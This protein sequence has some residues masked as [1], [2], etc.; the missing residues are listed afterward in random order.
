MTPPELLALAE[1]AT[2]GPWHQ[3]DL[4]WN[5]TGTSVHAGAHDP[6]RGRTICDTDTSFTLD[7]DDSQDIA[8]AAYIAAADP[9]TVIALL[10]VMEAVG[11]REHHDHST[12]IEQRAC[13]PSVRDALA[14]AEKEMGK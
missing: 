10:R 11:C 12:A 13:A 6:H 4:P 8:N 2:K 7:E 14:A 3:T 5:N 9:Q 1:A